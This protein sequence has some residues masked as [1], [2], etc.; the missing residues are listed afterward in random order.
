MKITPAQLRLIMTSLHEERAELWAPYLSDAMTEFAIATPARAAGFL[1]QVAHES[2]E[3]SALVESMNYSADRMVAVWPSRFGHQ[4]GAT[5]AQKAEGRRRAESLDHKPTELALYVYGSRADLGN[6]PGTFD[7]ADFIGR[8]PLAVTGRSNY[9][10]FGKAL[11]LPLLENPRLLE[12]PQHGSRAA[13]Y[14]W[15]S[16]GLNK[17]VDAGEAVADPDGPRQAVIACS[18]AINLGSV[19]AKGAPLGLDSRLAYWMRARPALAD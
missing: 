10:A 19:S 5:A 12:H 18:R 11:G 1:A 3:L 17:V 14:F 16:H 7:G 9:A 13:A 15:Q 8:G 6:R 4:K 2:R